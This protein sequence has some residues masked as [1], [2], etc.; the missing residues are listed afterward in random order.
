MHIAS[1]LKGHWE[2]LALAVMPDAKLQSLALEKRAIIRSRKLGNAQQLLRLAWPYGPGGMSLRTMAGFSGG[3]GLADISDVAVLK[4]LRRMSDWLEAL[5]CQVLGARIKQLAINSRPIV[6]VDATS[7]VR[8]GGKTSDWVLHCRYRPGLGFTGFDL[9]DN[10]AGEHL[11]SHTINAGDLVIADRAYAQ[12]SGL[13]YTRDCGADYLVRTGWRALAW[14][15]EQGRP[16]DLLKQFEGLKPGEIADQKIAVAT[17]GG[18]FTTRLIVLAKSDKATAR[19]KRNLQ[20]KCWRNGRLLDPRSI[21]AARYLML[22]TSLDAKEHSPQDAL[23]LY[24]VRWQ[25]ELAFKRLKSILRLGKL[26]A[27]DKNLARA[28]LYSHLLLA[29]II[30]E[31]T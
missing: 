14:R 5:V 13:V 30:D 1:L 23:A 4:A 31:I 25:I 21:T 22:V 3:S 16:L 11:V 27:K 17:K 20:R 12:S 8:P 2:K 10:H 29:L 19:A 6:L 15:D 28:W 24:R 18:F 7:V 26:P 9:T